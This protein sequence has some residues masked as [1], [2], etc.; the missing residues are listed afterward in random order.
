MDRITNPAP[1]QRLTSPPSSPTSWLKTNTGPMFPKDRESAIR[2]ERPRYDWVYDQAVN[3]THD[4]LNGVMRTQLDVWHCPKTNGT[5]HILHASSHIVD[6]PTRQRIAR[7][8]N[9]SYLEQT[10]QLR[11]TYDPSATGPLGGG[12]TISHDGTVRRK[13]QRSSTAPGGGL[14][15]L[16]V[17]GENYL[18]PWVNRSQYE[19]VTRTQAPNWAGNGFAATGHKAGSPKHWDRFRGSSGSLSP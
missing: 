2:G 1:T 19:L 18:P 14:R 12:V 4:K 6:T 16:Q 13:L 3:A 8:Y 10:G 17:A 15:T 5:Q 7:W 11:N 9:K